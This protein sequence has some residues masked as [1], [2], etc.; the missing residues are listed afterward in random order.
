[1]LVVDVMVQRNVA[2]RCWVC[3]GCG[4]LSEIEVISCLVVG[5][6]FLNVFLNFRNYLIITVYGATT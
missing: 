3:G 6:V 1:M 4:S 5:N 2:H